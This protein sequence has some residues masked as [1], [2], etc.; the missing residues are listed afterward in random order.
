MNQEVKHHWYQS[1]RLDTN[2]IQLCLPPIITT[3]IPKIQVT[4]YGLLSESRTRS[5]STALTKLIIEKV[6]GPVPT[7]FHHYKLYS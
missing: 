7:T 6:Y 5:F 3:Y 4:N 2:P 1:P